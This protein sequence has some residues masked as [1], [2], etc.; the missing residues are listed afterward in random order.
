MTPMNR[1]S[2]KR[3]GRFAAA[4]FLSLL[5]LVGACASTPRPPRINDLT[6]T[7]IDPQ[8]RLAVLR[9]LGPIASHE[10]PAAYA[11][12]LVSVAVSDAQPDDL[13]I[14]VIDRLLADD[15]A[16]L[17][18]VLASHLTVIDRWPVIEHVCRIAAGRRWGDF[19]PVLI[20]SYA[21]PSLTVADA[22]RPERRAIEAL[23]PGVPLADAVFAVFDAPRG[24]VSE[25]RRLAAW[26]LLCRLENPR[27]RVMSATSDAVLVR[28][29]HHAAGVMDVL[30]ST[31]QACAMLLMSQTV[32]Q[33]NTIKKGGGVAHRHYALLGLLIDSNDRDYVV[34]Q[35]A[36]ARHVWRSERDERDAA[37]TESFAGQLDRLSDADVQV[38]A[39][40]MRAMEIQPVVAQWFAQADADHADT[41][42]EHGGVLLRRDDGTIEAVAY[43]SDGASH[44]QQFIAP[45]EMLWRLAQGGVHYHFHAQSHRNAAFAGPGPGDLTFVNRYEVA[46]IVLTFIDRDTLNVDYYQPNGV[47]IDLGCVTR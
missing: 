40:V 7:D 47:V 26:S 43:P 10:Q 4:L 21:R 11:D 13:R 20:A 29:L 18:G 31:P 42:T 46:A 32:V 45:P 38:I 15:E 44:D 19:V 37:W 22:D 3:R 24:T 39:W 8:R 28:T 1:N 16:R 2:T 41:T 23:R 34:N 33:S 36:S 25:G 30:P 12:A 17:R 9:Q 6:N 35:L 27:Q 14:A 5:P